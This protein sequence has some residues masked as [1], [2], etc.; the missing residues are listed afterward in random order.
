M[1]LSP[2]LTGVVLAGGASSRMGTPKAVL[3]WAGEPVAARLTRLFV[4][5][6]GSA[7][8]VLGHDGT[9]LHAAL[10]PLPRALTVVNHAPQRGMLSS[11]Q[12]GLRA[13]PAESAALFFLPVDYP[14]IS[15]RTIAALR[16]AWS[17]APHAQIVLP[18]AGGRRGHPVLVSR[19]V[20]QELLRL[21]PGGAAHTV[22]RSDES[23]ILYVDVEDSA[24]HRDA[25]D[26]AAFAALQKEF[27]G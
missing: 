12:C 8:L 22:I 11:L 19:A 27:G 5:A 1:I 3:A 15:P 4:E 20:A 16:D 18:R 9:A 17:A 24:I 2:S 21:P 14:A 6:L 23:R 7:L 13:A 25:D 26:A 10:P